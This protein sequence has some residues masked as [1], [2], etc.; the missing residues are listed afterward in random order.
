VASSVAATSEQLELPSFF[1]LDSKP[2]SPSTNTS[3]AA[4]SPA[5]R[6]LVPVQIRYY[7]NLPSQPHRTARPNIQTEDLESLGLTKK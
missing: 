2:V 1:D 6:R 7:E 3:T 4:K 5:K